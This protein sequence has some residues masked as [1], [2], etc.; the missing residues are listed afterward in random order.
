[1]KT[2]TYDFSDQNADQRGRGL[3][4]MMAIEAGLPEAKQVIY[5]Q[6]IA[7]G[8]SMVHVKQIPQKKLQIEHHANGSVS[9][10]VTTWTTPAQEHVLVLAS[11]LHE[12]PV[13]FPGITRASPKPDSQPG[14]V[15]S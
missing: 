15:A 7:L 5:E 11:M 4:R 2:K 12:L 8:R 14:Q 9:G 1:M 10:A 3:I 6:L 13:C